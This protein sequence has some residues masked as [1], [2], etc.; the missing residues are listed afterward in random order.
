MKSFLRIFT[1]LTPRQVRNCV[2][3]VIMMLFGAILETMGIAALYPLIKIISKPN[4]L[5]VHKRLA[6]IIGYVG[7]RS[8]S[9]LV[10]VCSLGMILFYAFKNGY[11]MMEVKLQL[12]FVTGLQKLF[13]P[14]LFASYLYKP[15][16]YH[17]NINSAELTR[18]IT[19]SGNI[20]FSGILWNT[21]LIATELITIL[22]I[23]LSLL[24]LNWMIA[25]FIV[26]IMGPLSIF[27]LKKFRSNTVQQSAKKR[28]SVAEYMKWIHQ[29]LDSVKET[30]VMHREDF[31]ASQ[32]GNAYCVFA[33]SLQ[34]MQFVTST[35]RSI[36]EM[37]GFG[38]IL[39]MIICAMLLKMNPSNLVP[40]LGVLSVAATRLM[41][42]MTRIMTSFNTVKFSLPHL[43]GIYSDLIKIKNGED[44]VERGIAEKDTVKMP[45][46]HEIK[47][48]NLSFR[49]PDTDVDVLDNVSFTI[50][51]G[52]F[53]GIVGPSGAGKTTFVDVLL[54]LLP[55][56]Q[57]R[58]LVDGQDVSTNPSGWLSNIA[59][60]PQSI[61]LIDSTIRENITIGVKDDEVD[62]AQLEK[63]M[64]MA[65]IWDFVQ[66]LPSGV[67]TSVGEMGSHLSG[68]QKQRIGIARALYREPELLVLDEATSAL[69]NE[70]EKS[71]TGTILKL[72]NSITIISIAHRL[73]T[74]ANCDF[75]IRLQSGKATRE[76]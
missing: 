38:A 59:Y 49:Y 56:T 21:L 19:D 7:I 42:S 30:K 14:R 76:G 12:R 17:V 48:E 3:L 46:E 8:H 64:R 47:I 52:A 63:A 25:L 53:V 23:W 37:M 73:T 4:Y 70:T 55:P 28:A 68:G 32:F 16:L 62:E 36:V 15:Y 51:K 18:N 66:T 65:E 13:V 27:V 20:I 29:G 43:D 39:I 6:R 61:Y 35:P 31:F 26:L 67:L 40:T 60:V 24:K 74:L 2:L 22:V 75:K 5:E 72:K 11:I 33:N 50:P 57:G 1:I 69:D 10:I 44:N 34:Y 41:P 45:F 58:I 54:G 71:I 9:S